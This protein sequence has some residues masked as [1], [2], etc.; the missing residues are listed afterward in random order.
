MARLS[1]TAE[2]I[3]LVARN[4]IDCSARH[5]TPDTVVRRHRK[6]PP[7]QHEELPPLVRKEATVG[8]EAR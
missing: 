8:N 5:E 3:T 7:W 6:L 4:A 1:T 2:T